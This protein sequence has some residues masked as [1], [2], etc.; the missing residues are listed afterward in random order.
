MAR[1]QVAVQTEMTLDERKDRAMQELGEAIERIR[2][3]YGINVT[4]IIQENIFVRN[5]LRVREEW[6]VIAL[7]PQGE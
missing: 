2:E 6:A 4:P 3:V 5:G 7:S 1:K